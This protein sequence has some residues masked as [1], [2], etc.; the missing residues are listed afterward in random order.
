MEFHR[1]YKTAK[2]IKLNYDGQPILVLVPNTGLSQTSASIM[3]FYPRI[4]KVEIKDKPISQNMYN[5]I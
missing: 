1:F 2:F 3:H 4:F 5:A